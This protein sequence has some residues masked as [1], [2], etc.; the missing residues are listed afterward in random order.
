MKKNFV[1]R[2]SFLVLVGGLVLGCKTSITQRYDTFVPM[3]ESCILTD[4][5]NISFSIYRIIDSKPVRVDAVL[6]PESKAIIPAGKY[7]IRANIPEG[8]MTGT[9]VF[10]NQYGT[11]IGRSPQVG[12]YAR[13]YFGIFDF[14]PGAEYSVTYTR[15]SIREVLPTEKANAYT[16]SDGNIYTMPLCVI[17]YMDPK[18]SYENIGIPKVEE[19]HKYNSN[20][21]YFVFPLECPKT[22]GKL[23]K[24]Y[25]APEYSGMTRFGLMNPPM[26]GFQFGNTYGL[27]YYSNSLNVHLNWEWGFGIGLGVAKYD[28]S[29]FEAFINNAGVGFPINFGATA[30]F[31]IS[32]WSFG[33]GGGYLFTPF[34]PQGVFGTPYVQA[35]INDFFYIDYYFLPNFE[36]ERQLT[37]D[38]EELAKWSNTPP[39]LSFGLGIKTRF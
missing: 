26:L 9:N 17:Y 4:P 12:W 3:E 21:I 32:K 15:N 27:V 14:E 22:E 10:V 11:E 6:N 35:T 1:L 29:S 23:G 36:I 24:T 37:W 2:M 20:Y 34:P 19:G 16:D 39:Y 30:E 13:Y 25:S 7:I 8:Q 18:R 5:N 33:I 31:D 38:K 28:F